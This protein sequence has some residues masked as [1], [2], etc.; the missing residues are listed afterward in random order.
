MSPTNKRMDQV[1]EAAFIENLV[2]AIAARNAEGADA[3]GRMRAS[4]SYQEVDIKL[5]D[6]ADPGQMAAFTAGTATVAHEAGESHVK[7]TVAADGDRALFRTR[8]PQRYRA[9]QST[10]IIPTS[11]VET[12]DAANVVHRIGYF[13][14]EDGLFLQV[15]N[16]VVSFVIRDGITSTEVEIQQSAW[17]MDKF[18]GTGDSGV[19][20]DFTKSLLM[21]IDFQYLGIGQVRFGFEFGGSLIWAHWQDFSNESSTGPYMKSANLHLGWEIEA[22]GAL[23]AG[24]YTLRAICGTVLREGGANE[25]VTNQTIS[26]AVTAPATIPASQAWT[27]IL[28]VRIKDGYK[29]H[30]SALPCFVD[31]FTAASEDLA[32]SI[33]RLPFSDAPALITG[34]AWASV[35]PESVSEYSTVVTTVDITKGKR[36]GGGYVAGGA[37]PAPGTPVAVDLFDSSGLGLTDD[38]GTPD[39]QLKQDVLILVAAKLDNAGDAATHGTLR[40][41]EVR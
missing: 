18:D 8:V 15:A 35:G 4:L 5:T 30:A 9:G 40:I 31:V 7:L 14:E 32:W 29:E 6:D 26:R 16:G 34:G 13:N 33:I 23:A 37:G 1:V 36:Y 3:F 28:A 41:I 12:P 25:P 10:L 19:A 11:I 22:T 2:A 24:P 27:S 38:S 17:N 21:A 39:I 20:I